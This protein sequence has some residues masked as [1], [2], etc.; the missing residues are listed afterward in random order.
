MDADPGNS[1]TRIAPGSPRPGHDRNPFPETESAMPKKKTPASAA[2]PAAKP[3]P[4]TDIPLPPAAHAVLPLLDAV[5]GAT[6][7]DLAERAGLGRSTVT[8]ALATLGDAGLAARKPGGHDGARRVADL[9]FTAPTAPSANPNGVSGIEEMPDEAPGPVQEPADAAVDAGSPVEAA[10]AAHDEAEPDPDAAA[11]HDRDT[12]APETGA[13]PGD[14]G[15][16]CTPDSGRAEIDAADGPGAVAAPRCDE[17]AEESG[18]ARPANEGAADAAASTG[19]ASE[20]P[21]KSADSTPASARLGK[22]QLRDRVAEHLRAHPDRDWTPSA[23]A[24]E[25]GRSAG[26]ISNAGE[27][28]VELGTATTFED[29]P[30]RFRYS[31]NG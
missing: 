5:S 21:H 6:T 16:A 25:L 1:E 30:R 2:S 9:W 15:S 22:G 11:G 24:K 14:A 10:E 28:L 26:A 13:E 23:I 7:A 31:G 17:Q 20:Q 27:K 18:A 3:L 19:V 8:K 12:G 4:P 29:K